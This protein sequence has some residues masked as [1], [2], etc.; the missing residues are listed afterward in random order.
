M[1]T[2]VSHPEH[3]W[4][5][6]RS[7]RCKGV[8]AASQAPQLKLT[9]AKLAWRNDRLESELWGAITGF[10]FRTS[11]CVTAESVSGSFTQIHQEGHLDATA[12]RMLDLN[13]VVKSRVWK[14]WAKVSLA[15]VKQS[16][17]WW[18]LGVHGSQS[19]TAQT[20][21]ELWKKNTSIKSTPE[22]FGAEWK[23]EASPVFPC[24]DGTCPTSV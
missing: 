15:T 1:V 6:V 9:R 23:L 24:L 12:T 10:N 8:A 2:Q 17:K 16:N 4:S 18:L 5:K 3:P 20:T 21:L 22:D 11:C 19:T 14:T 7:W 13:V